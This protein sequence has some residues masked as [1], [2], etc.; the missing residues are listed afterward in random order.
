MASPYRTRESSEGLAVTGARFTV[1]SVQSRPRGCFPLQ[2]FAYWSR[3]SH[4]ISGGGGGGA[5]SDDFL[6][7]EVL[8]SR[9]VSISPPP[10]QAAPLLKA[11]WQSQGSSTGSS[12][13]AAPDK[14][15]P[16]LMYRLPLHLSRAFLF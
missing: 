11:S 13:P 2:N 10:H 6:S 16:V 1:S 12:G 3:F 15:C 8:V 5:G 9:W 14:R 4:E 7:L